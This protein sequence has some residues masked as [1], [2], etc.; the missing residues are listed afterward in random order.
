M[1]D[2]DAS[3]DLEARYRRAL[4]DPEGRLDELLELSLDYGR[5]L[6]EHEPDHATDVLETACALLGDAPG[7]AHLAVAVELTGALA[8]V[9]RRVG[10]VVG[11]YEARSRQLRLLRLLPVDEAWDR[12]TSTTRRLVWLDLAADRVD[13]GLLLL[14][15]RA[16]SVV[17]EDDRARFDAAVVELTHWVGSVIAGPSVSSAIAELMRVTRAGHGAPDREAALSASLAALHLTAGDVELAAAH[18]RRA[19]ALA[20]SGDDAP[21]VCRWVDAMVAVAQGEVGRALPA[22]EALVAQVPAE[23]GSSLHL[24]LLGW[25]GEARLASGDAQ[26]AR[27]ALVGAASFDVGAERRLARVHEL[28]AELERSDGGMAA[29]YEH[30]L[31]CRRYEARFLLR[32]ARAADRRQAMLRPVTLI[33]PPRLA[34]ASPEVDGAHRAGDWTGR[35][36]LFR[37]A[38][39]PGAPAASEGEPIV[40]DVVTAPRI[41]VGER[42]DRVSSLEDLVD[43]RTRELEQALIDLRDLSHRSEMD[44]LTGLINRARLRSLLAEMAGQGTAV[45]VLSIDVDRFG[46]LNESL[47]HD[48]GD[49]LLVEIARRL[50][51]IARTADVVGR[52]GSDEFVVVL[53]G[54]VDEAEVRAAA[55]AVVAAIAVPW[56]SPADERVVPSACVGV[57]AVPD[58]VV[59]A[60]L[61]LR[62]A[63]AARQQA[64]QS[65]LGR[66][67]WFGHELSDVAR[68][69]F[70]T[71]LLI[72]D[73]LAEGWFELYF[74]P[75]HPNSDRDPMSAEALIRMHHPDGRLLAPGAF[76][77]VAE[78]TGL[79]Q[80]IGEWV[81]DETARIAARW[82]RSGVPFR[83]ALN[84]SASQLDDGFVDLVDGSLARHD[85][86]P[87]RL[88]IELTEHTLLEAD[89]GQV[90]SITALRD[91][92]I[93][94]ALDDFGTAYSSLNHLRRFPVDVVKIDRS[95][96][97]GIC[98]DPHDHAIVAAVVQLSLAFGFRVIAEGIET[99]EQLDAQRRLGCHGAQGYLIG[100]P[101]PADAFERLLSS[102][103]LVGVLLRTA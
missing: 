7:A 101:R 25:L 52:W 72:R 42:D 66:V 75:V 79:A 54:T 86:A 41:E 19:A 80:P 93:G 97:A 24:E 35:S 30:L 36:D 59:D 26:G 17:A 12:I 98:H 83:V 14:V 102:R 6:V 5:S 39:H 10:D 67:E 23:A 1:A 2:L 90:A 13:D 78:D 95:F 71:E 46:R 53:V 48:I 88:M 56:R 69:R 77:D 73:A 32:T 9:R 28:L 40:P 43:S 11:E 4:D 62:Q 87:E 47:G 3:G 63:D 20:A 45:S 16:R 81:I 49:Q 8:R 85:L 18:V 96:V 94:L 99:A 61:V 82:S 34:E 51:R 68:R 38:A 70:D 21:F 100:P 44:Q 91:R 31:S 57:V 27:A 58:G 37:R 33:H 74:Q 50:R 103:E 76:L 92:G 15:E 64:K 84:V 55:E 22:L 65:G 89:A 29:A 60:D